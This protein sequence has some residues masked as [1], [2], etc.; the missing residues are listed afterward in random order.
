MGDISK[1]RNGYPKLEVSDLLIVGLVLNFYTSSV[2][3][4]IEFFFFEF[5]YLLERH[6]FILF[7]ETSKIQIELSYHD[8]L[9][10]IFNN[11]GF[12]RYLYLKYS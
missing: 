9:S 7:S 11:G 6:E 2:A 8:S 3:N 5:V 1:I 4:E 10:E 12:N